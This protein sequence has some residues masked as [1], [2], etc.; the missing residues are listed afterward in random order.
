[1]GNIPSRFQWTDCSNSDIIQSAQDPASGVIEAKSEIH[2]KFKFVVKL[3]GRFRFFFRCDC[4][5]LDI[6]IGFELSG[7]VYGLEIIYELPVDDPLE[8]LKK[9]NKRN[10]SISPMPDAMD[11]SQTDT[12]NLGGVLKNRIYKKISDG[13]KLFQ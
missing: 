13:I 2:I 5:A 4:D 12:I 7:Y 11:A 3:F 6:P 9:F 10:S 8:A 1:M